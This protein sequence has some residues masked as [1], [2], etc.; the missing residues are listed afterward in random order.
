MSKAML[1]SIRSGEYLSPAMKRA[2]RSCSLMAA[3]AALFVC[4]L[5]LAQPLQA[6]ALE[7]A[8]RVLVEKSLH[9]L[10]LWRGERQLAAFHVVFGFNP[11]G[12]KQQEGDGRTPEGRYVLDYKKANSEYYKA[13]RIS[14]PN[15]RDRPR[16][17]RLGV[18]PGGAIMIHGQPNGYGWAQELTQRRNWTLGCIALRNEDMDELWQRV[19][20]GTA[21]EIRP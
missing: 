16:A 21:I 13:I 9:R 6:A 3:T 8:D 12:H 20:A 1:K 11:Q 17:R 18:P 14:Y 4:L 15:A 2:G 19:A 7:K 5:A 10:T